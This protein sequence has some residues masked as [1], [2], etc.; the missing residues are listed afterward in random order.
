MARWLLVNSNS[1]LPTCKYMNHY[2]N[3]ITSTTRANANRHSAGRVQM[4]IPT[5]PTLGTTTIQTGQLSH[6][7]RPTRPLIYQ[8]PLSPSQQSPMCDNTPLN[9]D[10]PNKNPH[11]GPHSFLSY[12]GSRQR[13]PHSSHQFPLPH[14]ATP[15]VVQGST[16]TSPRKTKEKKNKKTRKY[17]K[18]AAGRV[19]STQK[20]RITAI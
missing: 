17:I 18:V 6:G 11:L 3:D 8:K 10:P 7:G 12:L 14:P 5:S 2:G 4:W 1:P 9:L 19:T 15:E 20:S 13:F 16:E